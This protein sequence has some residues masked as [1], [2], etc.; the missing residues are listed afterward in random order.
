MKGDTKHEENAFEKL[1]SAFYN[2]PYAIVSFDEL[3]R[4]EAMTDYYDALPILS[5]SIVNAILA[6]W[7]FEITYERASI[8][9]KLLKAVTKL[10]NTILFREA[11]VLIMG[12]WKSP[13][14]KRLEE[15]NDKLYKIAERSYEKTCVRSVKCHEYT[16]ISLAEGEQPDGWSV[17]VSRSNEKIAHTAKK[18]LESVFLVYSF[19]SFI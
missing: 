13:M 12:P 17:D 18:P 15:K 3:F 6:S 5:Q 14:W 19:R 9:D 11:L 7:L 16:L 1:M 8:S 4:I 2:K 10:K